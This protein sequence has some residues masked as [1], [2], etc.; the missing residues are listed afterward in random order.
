[1]AKT[2]EQL[3][4]QGAQ[5]K[6]ATVVG[7]NTATRVGTLFTDIVEHVE[8]YEAE[9]TA[10]T[11]ANT[12]AISNE[13]Q[14]RTKADEQL[15]TTIVTEKSRAEAAEKANAQA[16]ADETERA[17]KA[18]QANMEETLTTLGLIDINPQLS[19][20]YIDKTG[21]YHDNDNYRTTDPIALAAG[22]IISVALRETDPNVV[23]LA[24]CNSDGT[25][26]KN[27]FFKNTHITPASSLYFYA[28]EDCYV[29]VSGINGAF[30]IKK[31]KYPK[32]GLASI[33]DYFETKNNSVI[34][35][36]DDIYKKI[37]VYE[38]SELQEIGVKENKFLG[39]AGVIVGNS[40][41][42]V[43]IY[44]IPEGLKQV[45]IE[46]IESANVVSA[47]AFNSEDISTDTFVKQYKS[48][49]GISEF[50]S[51]V[52]EIPNDATHIGI[53][54]YKGE[55]F[56]D[57][58]RY[59]AYEMI[60]VSIQNLIDNTRE[61]LLTE[62]DNRVAE[63]SEINEKI[64]EISNNHIVCYGDSLTYGSRATDT[65]GGKSYPDNLQELLGEDYNVYNY[66]IPGAS[67]Q[68]IF[69][70]LGSLT[71][72]FKEDIIVSKTAWIT[73][74]TDLVS[75]DGNGLSFSA[76]SY[77]DAHYVTINGIMMHIYWDNTKGKIKIQNIANQSE[78]TIIKAGDVINFPSQ[79]NNN[80]PYCTIIWAGTNGI[81]NTID[82]L[83][84]RINEAISFSGA[85]RAIV[86]SIYNSENV[87]GRG[88]VAERKEEERVLTLHFGNRLINARK[89]LV[90]RGLKIAGLTA[91]D[92]DNIFINRGEVPPSLRGT[93]NDLHLNG[94]GY[95]VIAK[96]IY[97]RGQALR[98]W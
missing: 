74:E 28:I 85:Q 98:Y 81:Y 1:M 6:N 29:L 21:V 25:W 96:E 67:V 43:I 8:Q 61:T 57:R 7:E 95:F 19:N 35:I 48:H 86:I 66:G 58:K 39:S 31:S 84:Q 3:K 92:D 50:T 47:C 4:A 68:Q 37:A 45:L 14:E 2:I 15:N 70:R 41:F 38:K 34:Q 12:L 93:G 72:M 97:Q 82:E 44:E 60:L 90:E 11:E 91:T 54:R 46:G 49:A 87:G 76:G 16:I 24:L 53:T 79:V 18:E 36:T 55:D 9:Q 94:Y 40:N 75:A 10:D 51:F 71:A 26:I 77:L 78:D 33:Y 62:N 65:E 56:P 52:A 30:K 69:A 83:I 59:R 80:L 89:L 73:T 22:E 23:T 17:T 42:D 88:T 63:I 64:N 5:V 27:I 13:A 32:F 20:K